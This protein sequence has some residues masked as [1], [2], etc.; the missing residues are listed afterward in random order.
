MSEHFE[1][2]IKAIKKN[3]MSPFLWMVFNFLKTAEPLGGDSLL[4]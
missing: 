1:G 2:G 4:L 3:F